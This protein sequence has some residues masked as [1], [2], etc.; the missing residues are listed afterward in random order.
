MMQI[1]QQ[2]QALYAAQSD[3]TTHNGQ[4]T[5]LTMTPLVLP[6]TSATPMPEHLIGLGTFGG[7]N[8]MYYAA[9]ANGTSAP[10]N[11]AGIPVMTPLRHAVAASLGPIPTIVRTDQPQPSSPQSSSSSSSSSSLSSTSSSNS[12]SPASSAVTVSLSSSPSLRHHH[13]HHHL[14]HNNEHEHEHEHEHEQQLHDGQASDSRSPDSLPNARDMPGI[15]L[16]ALQF[17]RW[18]KFSTNYDLELVIDFEA[19]AFH[20]KHRGA[21][22]SFDI[23]V[24]FRSL[25]SIFVEKTRDN[26]DTLLSYQVLAPPHFL[27]NGQPCADFTNSGSMF[28]NFHTAQLYPTASIGMLCASLRHSP[29]LAKLLEMQL[30]VVPE[31]ITT[32][33]SLT[34]HVSRSL[35]TGIPGT[36]LLVPLA[37]STIEPGHRD[38]PTAITT[39]ATT[40]D[41]LAATRPAAL[42]ASAPAGS[43]ITVQQLYAH[44][45]QAPYA[46]LQNG[47]SVQRRRL[48][49]LLHPTPGEPKLSRGF[50]E[51]VLDSN[52]VAGRVRVPFDSTTS[53][54]PS[55]SPSAAGS[56]RI[57][58]P[59]MVPISVAQEQ[60]HLTH[61]HHD[62]HQHHLH[63]DHHLSAAAPGAL[64]TTPSSLDS[65]A[66]SVS[67]PSSSSESA[68]TPPPPVSSAP[69]APN[70]ALAPD[71]VYAFEPDTAADAY[72]SQQQLHPC[73]LGHNIQVHEYDLATTWP[74]PCGHASLTLGA[75]LRR[76]AV[77]PM[78]GEE[79]YF[80][81][82]RNAVESSSATRHCP[83]CGN[84]YANHAPCLCTPLS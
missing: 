13:H 27:R 49:P 2:N 68:T 9:S 6:T 3:A 75:L 25:S 12:S 44:A 36:P 46:S 26:T 84:C 64:S 47:S 24:D 72:Q 78:C 1:F 52:A 48:V 40:G 70:W 31:A 22:E 58:S 34:H 39:A 37:V 38:H 66:S 81:H 60:Q 56:D 18:V 5:P 33:G 20:Y 57:A 16:V 59:L 53:P 55:T 19:Q 77:C 67:T 50:D 29:I 82:C 8:E 11:V 41:Y 45:S 76:G 21:D 61:D 63:H 42:P 23:L 62:H 69:Y 71:S 28:W 30:S 83:L 43:Q 32:P 10:S 7:A 73:S 17:G 35:S 80:S 54:V 51:Q 14:H 65:S 74:L 4:A 79:Y 15:K